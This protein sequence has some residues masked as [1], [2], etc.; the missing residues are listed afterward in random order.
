MVCIYIYICIYIYTLY[1]IHLLRLVLPF[2]ENIFSFPR[3]WVLVSKINF[4][5]KIWF[6]PESSLF[7][8]NIWL[9]FVRK[10]CSR[11]KIWLVA[12]KL[13]TCFENMICSSKHIT[14]SK[15]RAQYINSYLILQ[16]LYIPICYFIYI[17]HIY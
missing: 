9:C 6:F 4:R 3:S 10:H 15:K 1:I 11:S 7:D 17:I 14:Y 16:K 5:S 2:F 12:E 13:I 8:S